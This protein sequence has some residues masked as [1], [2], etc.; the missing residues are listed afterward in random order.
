[1]ANSKTRLAAAN[2]A[3][4]NRF[5]VSTNMINGAYSVANATMPTTP[6]A[7]R[8]TVTHTAVTGN[9]TLGTIT[10]TGTDDRGQVIVDVIVP[11]AGAVATGTKFFKTVTGIVGAGW[12]I[13]TGNDTIVVGCEAG[14]AVLD[15]PG[16]LKSIIVNTTAAGT[17]SL[18]DASGT[19]A[20]LKTSIAEGAYEYDVDIAGFLLIT[21]AAASDVTVIHSPRLPSTYA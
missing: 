15:C 19:F 13:N 4:P 5:V 1:V 10:V 7:R 11:L 6:G 3:V 17:I 18:T 9:D 16:L 20:V 14:S 12:V 2:P 8:I 21:L